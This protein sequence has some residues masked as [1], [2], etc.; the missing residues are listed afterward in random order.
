MIKRTWMFLA[1]AI[2]LVSQADA[3][4]D[5]FL[6]RDIQV[7]GN[8]RITDGT[9]FNYLPVNVGDVLDQQRIQEAIRALYE[10]KFF[11]D[12]TGTIIP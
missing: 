1:L 2:F 8:Q 6:V 11:D 3:Q 10:T 7:E 12:F 5:G 9:I 4:E